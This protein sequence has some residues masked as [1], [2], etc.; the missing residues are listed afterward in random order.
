MG[1]KDDRWM[2]LVGRRGVDVEAVAFDGHSAGLITDSAQLSVQVVPD[3]CFVTG[4]RFDVDK[5]SGERDG[6]HSKSIN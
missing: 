1:G 3:G 2:R 5:L 4:D 6:V